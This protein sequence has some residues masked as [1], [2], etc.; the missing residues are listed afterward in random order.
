MQFLWIIG[1]LADWC[2]KQFYLSKFLMFSS[3]FV[4]YPCKEFPVPVE[5]SMWH[6][7]TCSCAI[8]GIIVKVAD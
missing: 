3:H 6:A 2:T 5:N 7:N 8:L 4:R 1:K